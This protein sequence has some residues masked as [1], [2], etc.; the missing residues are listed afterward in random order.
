MRIAI[1][2]QT[3]H[4]DAN[5]QSVFT[6]NLAEGLAAAGHQV[7]VVRP[8]PRSRGGR[9][10]HHGVRIEEV[11]SVSL[12]F[13]QPDARL[14]LLPDPSVR[15]FIDAFQ[16]EIV[17]LQDHYPLCRGALRAARRRRTALIGTNHFLPDNFAPHL[18]L[19]GRLLGRERTDRWLWR[20]MLQV[21]ERLDIV[22]TPSLTAARILAAQGLRQPIHPI[23]C[24]VDLTRFRR[25]P[26]VDRAAL[27]A[28][29]GI[30]ADRIVFL[31]VGRVD[32]EKRLEVL[33]H[34]M[35]RLGR[36]D[37]QLAIA[38]R[39][40]H[41]RRLEALGRELRLGSRLVFTGYVPG[42]DLP[43]LLNSV[44][45]FA[46][47]SEAELQSIATL[48][49]MACARPVLAANARAL[50]ELV[51]HGLNGWLFQPG[52]AD[53]AARGMAELAASAERR[54][55]QGAASLARV[56]AHSVA[57]TWRL[58]EELYHTL[59]RG[60]IPLAAWPAAARRAARARA[61][62]EQLPG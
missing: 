57:N 32:G 17:H 34:A 42:E 46:M 1:V 60:T 14:T 10:S 52:R 30:A 58:Y 12:G 37:L 22:T 24:G 19:P 9:A 29:Y 35:A 41:R 26:E 36:D 8:S 2:G 27:R 54:A 13:L 49:A 51:E 50:P 55:T 25:L 21:Y 62:S 38:G 59:L 28:R 4:P 44:D 7:V 56:Q 33:L 61:Y 6:V 11:P 18:G 23:S 15:R 31:F 39:G 53:D 3:Y 48:E 43:G 47:P 20:Y 45:V 5:G 16:P 40:G